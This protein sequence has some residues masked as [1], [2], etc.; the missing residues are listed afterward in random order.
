VRRISTL[1]EPAGRTEGNPIRLTENA[2]I[3]FQGCTV[4]GMGFVLEPK[5]AQQWIT[6]DPRNAHVLFPYLNGEDL[7]QRPD[8]SASRWVI[9]FNDRSETAAR[10]YALPYERALREVKP[11]RAKNS[12]SNSRDCWWQFERSRP[13]MRKAIADLDEVLAI[14]LVSKTVMPVRVSSSHVF[15][16]KLGV[17]ATDQFADQALLSSSLHQ[18]WAVKYGSTMRSDVNYSPSDVFATFPRPDLTD[19]LCAAGRT[20]D[21]ERREMML[22]RALGLTKI[23]NLV[24]DPAIRDDRDVDRLRKIHIE[25]DEATVAAYGWDDIELDHGFC[26]YRQLKRWTVSPGARVEI[27]DRLLEENRFRANNEHLTDRA[28]EVSDVPKEEGTLFT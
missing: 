11:E 20:L 13:A 6:A 9:D 28:P 22:R 14:A 3:A 27:L 5:E 7:N 15:S 12:R 1:L 24:N 18:L 25:V 2:G 17:F 21:T 26:T 10:E 16:H 8:A 23:Y 4:L 19:R